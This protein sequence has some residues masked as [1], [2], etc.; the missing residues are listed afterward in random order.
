MGRDGTMTCSS[1][2]SHILRTFSVLSFTCNCTLKAFD[3]GIYVAFSLT[4]H[5]FQIE[6]GIHCTCNCKTGKD[7]ITVKCTFPIICQL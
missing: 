2:H 1:Y 3:C 6:N 5:Q 7:R 4:A